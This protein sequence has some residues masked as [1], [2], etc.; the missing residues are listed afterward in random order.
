MAEPVDEHAS[1]PLAELPSFAPSAAPRRGHHAR[2]RSVP[3]AGRLAALARRGSSQ[4]GMEQTPPGMSRGASAGGP[5]HRRVSSLGRKG[6]RQTAMLLTGLDL[7]PQF[8]R[9]NSFHGFPML[10]G[11]SMLGYRPAGAADDPRGAPEQNN[12]CAGL[13]NAIS[14]CLGRPVL[15]PCQSAKPRYEDDDDTMS[16]MSVFESEVRPRTSPL[17]PSRPPPSP[18]LRHPLPARLAPG[19]RQRARRVLLLAGV[20]AAREPAR[21]PA[22]QPARHAVLAVQ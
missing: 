21:E 14:R 11:A 12:V 18:P 16:M 3:D 19:L 1:P 2:S 9:E 7:R 4:E 20:H 8:S 10:A 22:R 15:G 17:A 5:G 13:R 6:G